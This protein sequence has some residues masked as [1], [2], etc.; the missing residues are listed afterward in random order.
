MKRIVYLI[1]ITALLAGC[2]QASVGIIGGADGPTKIYISES[3]EGETVAMTFQ[4]ISQ[5]AAKAIM[6][7]GE[8]CILVD[9]REQEEFAEGHIPDA[10]LMPY[11]Q[12]EQLAPQLLPDK[13]ARILVYCRSGRRSK[14]AAAKLAELGYTDVQEFGGII[15]WPYGT[16]KE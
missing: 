9:V 2:R 13:D 16:V 15:D 3:R 6:D 5:D 4:T 7:S 1:L 8:A 11:L 10:I 12:T 14:I